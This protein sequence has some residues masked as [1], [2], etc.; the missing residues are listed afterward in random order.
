MTFA[1]VP[2][3]PA[4]LWSRF[5]KLSQRCVIDVT[6]EAKYGPGAGVQRAWRVVIHPPDTVKLG[7][8][9][10]TVYGASSAAAIAEAVR[11][12]EAKGWM[13]EDAAATSERPRVAN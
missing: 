1:P 6:S 8:P 10:V 9:P 12:A 5:T 7:T 2:D 4:D 3:L 13:N 11:E